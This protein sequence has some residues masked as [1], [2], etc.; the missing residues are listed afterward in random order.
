MFVSAISNILIKSN[1]LVFF[2]DGTPQWE[3][4]CAGDLNQYSSVQWKLLN[5]AKL[6]KQAPDR[7]KEG[8]DKLKGY[9]QV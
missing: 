2:E 3:K 8:I 6:N 9:L 4:C 1:L 5:I 7:H